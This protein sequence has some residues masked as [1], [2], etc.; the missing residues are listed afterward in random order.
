MV[1]EH[2]GVEL[3]VTKWYDNKAVHLLNTYASACPTTDVE[4]WT[5]K[6]KKYTDIKCSTIIQQRYIASMGGVDFLG[7]LIA[8]YMI[9]IRARKW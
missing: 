8:L 3:W 7:S 6:E 5:K 2:D 4:W 9:G 1:A